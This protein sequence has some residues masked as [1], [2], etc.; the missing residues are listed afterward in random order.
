MSATALPGGLFADPIRVGDTVTRL[1]GPG[2]PNVHAL[3]RHLEQQRFPLSPRLL[4]ITGD[5]RREILSFLPGA[6]GHPPHTAAVRS[7]RAL[8]SAARAIRAL[9]DATVGFTPPE[10]GRWTVQDVALPVAVDCIGH[11]DLTL[12]NL[13]FDGDQ[14]VGI[15]DFDNAAPSNRAWDL[16]Y[17]AHWMVPMHTTEDLPNF[18]WSSLPGRARRLRILATAYDPDLSPDLLVDLAA[19][20]LLSI[21]AHLAQQISAGNPAYAVHAAGDYPAGYRRAAAHILTHRAHLLA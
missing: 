21:G 16:A 14:V 4:G 13:L 10:P 8:R 3:L 1:M 20:R 5:G 17:L 6:P 19:L 15:I 11:G 12:G 9:H 7:E 2:A 18:G